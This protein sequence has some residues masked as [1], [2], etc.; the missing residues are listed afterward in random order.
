MITA[1][2]LQELTTFSRKD[3]YAIL[4]ESGYTGWSCDAVKFLGITN[5]GQFCYSV[6]Y[7]D[8]NGEGPA[9]GKVF[10]TYENGKTTA[11]L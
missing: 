7:A 2:K 6:T 10:V 11:S 3:L 1:N 5:G 8:D 9:H 4:K